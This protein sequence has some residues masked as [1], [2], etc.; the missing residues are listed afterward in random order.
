MNVLDQFGF[1][2]FRLR[3][4]K[5]SDEFLLYY[6]ELKM[7]YQYSKKRLVDVLNSELSANGIDYLDFARTEMKESDQ[8]K[9]FELLFRWVSQETIIIDNLGYKPVDSLVFTDSNKKYFNLYEV[10]K[11][12]ERNDIQEKDWSLIKELILNLV[13]GNQSEFDYF[14][15]WIAWQVQNPLER[16]PTSI[17]LQG[18]HGTGKTKFCELVLKNIFGNNFCEIGQTDINSDYNEFILGKQLIVAN[19]VIH[20]DNKF[21]I[22]DKLKNYVTDEYLSINRKFKDTIYIRN[23]S[24][25]IFVTN[26]DMPLKIETGD[27]RYSV[28]KSKKLVDGFQFMN[29]LLEDLDNQLEGFLFHL[30]HIE[31]DYETVSV[32]V[33]NEAKLDLIRLSQNSVEE[34]ID[35]IKFIG[36]IENIDPSLDY[37][38]FFSS[39]SNGVGIFTDVFYQLY[40]KYCFQTGIKHTFTRRNFTHQLKKLG[41]TDSTTKI[42]NK[43]QRIILLEGIK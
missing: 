23:Y 33:S 26:N 31:L 6:K 24:Q 11:L 25:W 41:L 27:R 5:E 22:P 28:F 9:P 43:T 18:E 12:L 38:N 32:P 29:K 19:E 10:S 17:I 7:Y 1:K 2:I 14:V 20:N 15:S 34:F 16:M 3:G 4:A 36:G 21:L 40:L 30:N 35:H 8:T 13:G 39:T 37:T 42:E